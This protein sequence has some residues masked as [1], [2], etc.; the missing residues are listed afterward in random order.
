MIILLMALMMIPVSPK[1]DAIMALIMIILLMK[2]MKA[3]TILM[4]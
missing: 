3:A 2:Q 1:E 4:G